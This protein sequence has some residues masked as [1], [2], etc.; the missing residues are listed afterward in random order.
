MNELNTLSALL[1]DVQGNLTMGNFKNAAGYLK[2]I[3]LLAGATSRQCQ[4]KFELGLIEELE[5][6]APSTD[7]AKGL[8][9]KRKLNQREFELCDLEVKL[10]DY[11]ACASSGCFVD[12]KAAAETLRHLASDIEAQ[13]ETALFPKP[14]TI[15]EVKAWAVRAGIEFQDGDT[16]KGQALFDRL[17]K[18]AARKGSKRGSPAARRT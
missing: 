15:E 6:M 18:S 9:T 8:D 7:A 3:S 11:F 17:A 1:Q 12:S 16:A 10:A 13:G 5:D 4:Q 14:A 2:S